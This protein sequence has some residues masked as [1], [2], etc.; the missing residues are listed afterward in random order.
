MALKSIRGFLLV[1]AS[2]DDYM[3]ISRLWVP[4][5]VS[6]RGLIVGE[7]VSVGNPAIGYDGK[8]YTTE[9][10]KVGDKIIFN[11][12]E[13]TEIFTQEQGRLFR[14]PVSAVYAVLEISDESG[15]NTSE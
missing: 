14:V 11:V 15:N 7:V 6:S 4:T 8:L 5:D 3:K 2:W 10:I 9:G 13:A 12:L 1:K